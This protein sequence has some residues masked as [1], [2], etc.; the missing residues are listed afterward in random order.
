MTGVWMYKITTGE[1]I[2]P[3]GEVLSTGYSGHGEGLNNPAM[4]DVPDVGP[5]PQGFYSI[6]DMYNSPTHGPDTR[7]LTPLPGTNTF[8]RDD[9]ELHGDEVLHAG[10]HLASLGCIIQPRSTRDQMSGILQV[11][12]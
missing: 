4:Q 7:K 12:E 6:G 5:C 9:F 1:M 11:I 2:A 8:G 10:Q 3:G